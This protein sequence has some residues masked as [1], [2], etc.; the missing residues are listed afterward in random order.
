M[1]L[2][3][4]SVDSYRG[5][6]SLINDYARHYQ[7]AEPYILALEKG[8]DVFDAV[9]FSTMYFSRELCNLKLRKYENYQKDAVEGIFEY[10]RKTQFA[11]DSVSRLNCVYYCDDIDAA[12]QYLYEDCLKDGTFTREQVCLLEVEVDESRVYRY[13]QQLYNLA[14]EAMEKNETDAVFEMAKRY[15]SKERTKEPLNE[16]LCDSPNEVVMEIEL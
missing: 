14:M 16:I 11:S 5:D 4:Y 8:R 9:L 6:K 13:D 10:V 1:L 15:F 7:F 12:K 3:H 2:Y